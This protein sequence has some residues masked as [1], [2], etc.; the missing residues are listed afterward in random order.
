MQQWEKLLNE[1][2]LSIEEQQR[3]WDFLS[4]YITPRRKTLFQEKIA[5]RTYHIT[6]V[7]E[8]IYQERNASAVVRSAECFGV[9]SVHIIEN[10]NEYKIA[11]G[12]AKGADKWVDLHIYDQKEQ[13]NTEVCL[14]SLKA[15]G[16]RLVAT[17]PHQDDCYI[18]ELDLHY[19]T[20]FIMGGEKDGLTPTAMEMADAY[21]K[22]PIYGFT[23]SFNL[24]VAT[25]IILYESTRRLHQ[26]DIKWQL[27][28]ELRLRKL[29]EWTLK[30]VSDANK[31]LARFF[32]EQTSNAN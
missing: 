31:L 29:I 23:E 14:Q 5:H 1:K 17:T 24:S 15:Q 6:V 8:D 12:I 32:E 25:A 21:V 4:H 10:H 22:I 7:V 18:H 19:P 11:K 28:E 9:Q 16:Y 30:S 26:S 13:N 3:L 20:A 2:K 27:S